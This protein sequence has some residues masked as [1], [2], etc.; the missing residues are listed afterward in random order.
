MTEAQI[1]VNSIVPLPQRRQYGVMK[2]LV[3][4]L[5]AGMFLASCAPMSIYYRPG[6]PVSQMQADTTRCE[7]RALREA[8]VATQIRQRPPVYV[9]ARRVC[10]AAGN[11]WTRPGYWI[12]GDVYTVDVNRGLRARVLDLCMAEKG[13]QPVSLPPCPASVR[14]GA[15]ERATTRLPR[16][17]EDA[18]VIRYDDGSWQIVTPGG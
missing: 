5:V 11:C 9:A 14:A 17:T 7:V 15:P 4:L 10:D 8:P 18:C 16:L 1:P 12:E 6:V 3:R 2:P 13:Y